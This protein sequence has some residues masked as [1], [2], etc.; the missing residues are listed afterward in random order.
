MCL[1]APFSSFVCVLVCQLD[2]DQV[3]GS[4][5]GRSALE[6]KRLHPER[7]QGRPA[8]AAAAAAVRVREPPSWRCELAP[9]RPHDVPCH[10]PTQVL[11]FGPVSH[12]HTKGP[13]CIGACA[14][15]TSIFCIRYSLDTVL[16]LLFVPAHME[17]AISSYLSLFSHSKHSPSFE[18]CML[19]ILNDILFVL[20]FCASAALT[21]FFYSLSACSP[22]A[23]SD[24]FVSGSRAAGRHGG[25]GQSSGQSHAPRRQ[26][27]RDLGERLQVYHLCCCCCG[28]S[29]FI[30]TFF[31]AL[32][33]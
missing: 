3:H 12:C 13:R 9:H 24:P 22:G 11:L 5:P 21:F 20:L 30:S 10:L 17:W 25:R 31:A 26:I 23:V 4:A 2:V 27:A 18:G 28:S 1:C 7:R 32:V 6:P 29:S 15:G 19:P 8:A 14:R 16:S 33:S